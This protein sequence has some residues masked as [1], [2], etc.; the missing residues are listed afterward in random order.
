MSDQIEKQF[1]MYRRQR[2]ALENGYKICQF[3]GFCFGPAANN[4]VL[5]CPR[6]FKFQPP[7]IQAFQ[8]SNDD[9]DDDTLPPLI[10]IN[11]PNVSRHSG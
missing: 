10:A 3:C 11:A 7:T 2:R 5:S 9:N 1:N 6:C 4:D 8:N